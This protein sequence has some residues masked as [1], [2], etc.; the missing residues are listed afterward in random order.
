MRKQCTGITST[1]IH[2]QAESRKNVTY[3]RLLKV[4]SNSNVQF[5]DK[6][7]KKICILVL[8]CGAIRCQEEGDEALVDIYCGDMNCYDLLGVPRDTADR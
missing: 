4:K 8:I 2:H 1:C 5:Q 3:I 6:I 7:M